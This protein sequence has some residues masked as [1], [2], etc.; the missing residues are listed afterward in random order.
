VPDFRPLNVEVRIDADAPPGDVVTALARLLRR[1]RDRQR[2]E[3]LLSTDEN[4]TARTPAVERP[5]RSQDH[6][7][8]VQET[9]RVSDEI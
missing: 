7:G 5:G 9:E 3:S 8:I 6:H 1:L 4:I 2:G